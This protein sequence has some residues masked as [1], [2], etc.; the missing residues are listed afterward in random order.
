VNAT[1]RRPGDCDHDLPR[2][3]CAICTPAPGFGDLE[4]IKVGDLRA[5]DWVERFPQQ[6][7]IRG[8]LVQSG[9]RHID[10]SHRWYEQ[11]RPRGPK[12]PLPASR[13]TFLRPDAPVLDVP[14][15]CDL[16]VRRPLAK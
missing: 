8:C 10:A 1:D 14:R 5:G 11:S 2:A 3:T 16:I 6:R 13:I 4:T 12:M 7:R 15:D 9:V